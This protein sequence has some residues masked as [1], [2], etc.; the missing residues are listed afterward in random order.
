MLTSRGWWLLGVAAVMTLLGALLSPRYGPA[1]AVIGGTVL[2]WFVAEWAVFAYRVFFVLP[3]LRIKREI[4]DERKAVP[5]LWANN[6]F[7]VRVTLSLPRGRLPD[8]YLEDCVPFVVTKLSDGEQVFTSVA[9]GRPGRVEYRVKCDAPGELI[10]EGVRVRVTDRQGFFYKSILLKEGRRYPVLPRLT[11]AEGNRRGK[12]RHN[13][14]PPPGVHR[15]RQ[16]GG[17]SELQDLRDYLPGDPP[18][19]IAWK[20]SARKDKLITKELES[21][22]PIR[23]TLFMDA[24]ESVRVGPVAKSKLT[25]LA[26]LSAGVAEGVAVERDHVGL[27]IFDEY[28]SQMMRPNRSRTHLIDMLHLLAKAAARPTPLG[29]FADADALSKL[30]YPVANELYPELMDKHVNTLGFAPTGVSIVLTQFVFAPIAAILSLLLGGAGYFGLSFFPAAALGIFSVAA[31]L[32]MIRLVPALYW[33][34]ISDTRRVW[35]VW[36]A[37]VPPIFLVL[38]FILSCAGILA[39]SAEPAM[40][41]L[42][43][44]SPVLKAFGWRLGLVVLWQG[45]MVFIGIASLIWFIHG[46]TGFFGE[47]RRRRTQRKQLGL[48]FATLDGDEPGAEVHY[49]HDDQIFARRAMTFLADHQTR[50]PVR[51]YDVRGRYLFYSKPKLATLAAALN[52]GVSR[53]RDNELFVLLADLV[54]LVDDIDPLVRAVRVAVGR[55]HQVLVV[56]PWQEDMPLPPTDPADE[57]SL[58]IPR[59]EL[60]GERGMHALDMELERD[61]TERYHK[62]FFRL[63]KEFGRLGVTVVRAGHEETVQMVLDRMNR[64]RGMRG[65]R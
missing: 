17:G 10:F 23:A 30:S 60:M 8:V 7:D 25:R 57:F 45:A 59:A 12:K 28:G 13:I 53:G 22:V 58:K 6:E 54:D 65:R 31:V 56:I 2:V 19:M 51:L 16:P 26:N 5:L 27:V 32:Q 46:I 4:W 44:L 50:Y 33:N 18:K 42:N 47:G 64:L 52:Y 48:L 55:H 29:P 20:P 43:I 49:L 37:L 36:V 40:T 21:E 41:Y 14:F 15:L 38:G 61:Q 34:P 1:I 3:G 39:R 9:K 35:F 24:S 62:N 63:R 11:G